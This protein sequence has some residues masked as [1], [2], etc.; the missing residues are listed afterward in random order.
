MSDDRNEEI[1]TPR[2]LD[3]SSR[4]KIPAIL[5]LRQTFGWDLRT[6]HEKVSNTPSDLPPMT[7]GDAEVLQRRFAEESAGKVEIPNALER[8]ANRL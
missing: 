5:I 8:M 7:L 1:V 3:Y 6:A 2:L 4:G